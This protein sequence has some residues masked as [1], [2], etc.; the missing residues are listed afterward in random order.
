M[1]AL[2]QFD[3]LLAQVQADRG[4]ASAQRSLPFAQ[5]GRLIDP[6]GEVC[7][8]FDVAPTD[9]DIL[10]AAHRVS[11]E[12]WCGVLADEAASSHGCQLAWRLALFRADR[13]GQPRL[14]REGR[15]LW[16][17]TPLLARPGQRP[18]ELLPQL[19]ALAV[20]ALWQAGWRLQTGALR[21]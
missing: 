15:P 4:P 14:S 5:V 7:S 9:A 19:R 17:S 3:R 6:H 21:R 11:E 18:S 10:A 1:H 2:A 16:L 8:E 12:D 20:R 13:H